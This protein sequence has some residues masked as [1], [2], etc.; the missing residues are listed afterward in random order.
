M[1]RPTPRLRRAGSAYLEALVLLPLFVVILL[2]ALALGRA[3]EARL[4]A[5]QR[6]R[7][8]A[9]RETASGCGRPSGSTLERARALVRDAAGEPLSGLTSAL[10]GVVTLERHAG[11]ALATGSLLGADPAAFRTVTQFACNEVPLAPT[12]IVGESPETRGL[13]DR[14]VA[15]GKP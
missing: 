3:Y 1:P 13:V 4:L 6:A 10:F 7:E 2:C 14:L 5:G 9:W 15:G 11:E 8:A 12:R